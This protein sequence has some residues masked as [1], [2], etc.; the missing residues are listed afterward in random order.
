MCHS[1]HFFFFPPFTSN[2]VRNKKMGLV[3]ASVFSG[4][5]S[6]RLI[7]SQSK[8]SKQAKGFSLILPLNHHRDPKVPLVFRYPCCC[9]CFVFFTTNQR[10]ELLC[11][12]F[13]LQTSRVVF[14]RFLY[15]LSML[16]KEEDGLLTK[17][18]SHPRMIAIAPLKNKWETHHDV[19]HGPSTFLFH[20][21]IRHTLPSIS[22][23][24]GRRR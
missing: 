12:P 13:S 11:P 4:F 23:S 17:G 21:F 8:S 18:D 24:I 5:R 6:I 3:A 22:L 7:G 2:P 19:E 20:I 14:K 15:S 9:C 10:N 1:V 16:K